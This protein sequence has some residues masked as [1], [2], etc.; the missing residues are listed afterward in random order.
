M[1]NMFSVI[2][3]P[4]YTDKPNKHV[5]LVLLIFDKQLNWEKRT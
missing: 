5:I 3:L 1:I 2:L 4:I